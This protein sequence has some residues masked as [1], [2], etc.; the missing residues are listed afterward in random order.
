[1]AQRHLAQRFL[2]TLQSA[3]IEVIDY[4]ANGDALTYDVYPTYDP[5]TKT[6]DLSLTGADLDLDNIQ[7]FLDDGIAETPIDAKIYINPDNAAQGT[8]PLKLYLYHGD[9]DEVS[10]GEDYFSIGLTEVSASTEGLALKI[11]AGEEVFAKYYTGDVI[12]EKTI[13]NSI[14]DNYLMV[15]DRWKD[16]I[17]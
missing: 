12:F 10:E 11:E 5:T 4:D 14:E 9:D 2:V 8:M 7:S 16:Q 1:M 15:M 17:A 3:W 6:L 13:T